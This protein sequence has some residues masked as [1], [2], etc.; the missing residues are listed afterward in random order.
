MVTGQAGYYLHSCLYSYLSLFYVA[1]SWESI[2]SDNLT[3]FEVYCFIIL[4][5]RVVN[6]V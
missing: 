6:S 5:F 4:I 1:L 2:C 3:K